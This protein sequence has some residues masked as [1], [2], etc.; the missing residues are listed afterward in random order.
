MLDLTTVHDKPAL[1]AAFGAVQ[2]TVH[3]RFAALPDD[4][5]LAAPGGGWSPADDLDHLI[6]SARPV[7]LGLR[8]PRPL[9]G[10]LFGRARQP[11]RS[12]AEVRA[13]YQQALANGA[14][15]SGPYVPRPTRERWTARERKRR[16]LAQWD[17]YAGW[18][19]GGLRSWRETDLD[20]Y[21]LPHPILGQLT[22]REILFFTL[23]H[24]LSHLPPGE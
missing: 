15:A 16:L 24:N 1:V 20:R 14:E 6:R 4:R 17:R 12:Y 9:L 3:A 19:A 7:A 18:L 23:Y 13:V 2:Q 5:F 8:L 22:V 10:L 21:R 11:S